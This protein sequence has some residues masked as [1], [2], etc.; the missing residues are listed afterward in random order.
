MAFPATPSIRPRSPCASSAM[1]GNL[2]RP[3]TFRHLADPW[4]SRDGEF[5]ATYSWLVVSNMAFI[6]HFIYGMSSFP[7][8]NS[9]FFKMVIA[10]PTSTVMVRK[11]R[12]DK[13][14][15]PCWN[16]QWSYWIVIDQHVCFVIF[17]WISLFNIITS[18]CNIIISL[19][20]DQ[21]L[22]NI[23]MMNDYSDDR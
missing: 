2:W 9:C 12:T 19:A 10:P 1:A 11:W 18:L 22:M 20:N 8:M 15:L 14:W 21:Y 3:W 16:D 4:W 5:G 6:F 23:A 7:L 17:Q 13:W